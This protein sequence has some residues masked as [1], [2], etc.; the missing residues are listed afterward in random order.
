[1]KSSKL[2]AG[3]ILKAIGLYPGVCPGVPV[4]N[5][6][7]CSSRHGTL[8]K[9]IWEEGLHLPCPSISASAFLRRSLFCSSRTSRCSSSTSSSSSCIAFRFLSFCSPDGFFPMLLSALM[10][11]P[12]SRLMEAFDSGRR[13]RRVSEIDARLVFRDDLELLQRV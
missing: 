10:T 5:W 4:H 13:R 6:V 1:M 12:A 3:G 11:T 7:I 9:A 2:Q 8:G